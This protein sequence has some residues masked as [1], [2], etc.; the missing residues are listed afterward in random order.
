MQFGVLKER[1]VGERRV[2]L[3]PDAV[4]ALV[5]EGHDVV[6]EAESGIAA[7]FSDRDYMAAGAELAFTPHGVV[8]GSHAVL[9]V[10]AP[11]EEEL[12]LLVGRPRLLVG[13]LH[14]AHGSRKLVETL[15]ATES[16]AL[17]LELVGEA[18][19]RPVMAPMSEI[20]G[21]IALAL[22]Q[23]HLSHAG[24]GPGTLLGGWVGVP[25]QQV[26]VIGAGMAGVAAAREAMNLAARVTVLDVDPGA[27]HRASQ[28]LGKHAVTAIASPYE[29]ASAV[30]RA[31]VV[32]GAVARPGQPAPRV[33]S[34]S[35]FR[36]MKQG[37]L[38][39]DLSIDEGGCSETSRPTSLDDP[40]YVEQ[41]VRHLCVPNLPSVVAR[42]A[43][44]A[45]SIA[46]LPYLRALG[47]HGLD[48]ALRRNEPLFNSTQIF[49]GELVSRRVARFHGGTA[50]ALPDLL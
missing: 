6:V 19:R 38:F 9:K 35:H 40:I 31:D 48:E 28:A 15:L 5:A 27:L 13:F 7:G 36:T 46:V 37:S 32:I 17:A 50:R 4:R 33:L 10:R 18:G 43:S 45:H 41:G 29:I 44:R 3:T 24:G 23:F 8:H 12:D 16:T 21:R 47:R 11:M 1:R 49:R 25:P 14:L 26:T 39:V 42:T 34:R 20:G 30:E 22:V 2:A